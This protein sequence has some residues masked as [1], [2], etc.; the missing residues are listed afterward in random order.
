MDDV[1]EAE[2]RLDGPDDEDDF[3]IRQEDKAEGW[4]SRLNRREIA[5]FRD[6]FTYREVRE[7]AQAKDRALIPLASLD[8]SP[9][10]DCMCT[11]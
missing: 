10:V 5:N 7:R 4:A 9:R 8:D 2:Y 6:E 1:L 3:W 11:D